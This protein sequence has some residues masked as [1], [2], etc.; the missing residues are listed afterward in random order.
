MPKKA[1]A[2]RY[3]QAVFELALEANKLEQWQA[4]LQVIS[5]AIGDEAVMTVLE[6]PKVSIEQKTSLLS[7]TVRPVGLV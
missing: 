3:A 2:R 6:S 7:D 1:N 5:D 4:D